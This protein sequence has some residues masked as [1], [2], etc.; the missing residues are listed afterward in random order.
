[1]CGLMS[2]PEGPV[3]AELLI[4]ELSTVLFLDLESCHQEKPQEDERIN[5]VLNGLWHSV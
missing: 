4:P 5:R 1:M 3:N 2:T